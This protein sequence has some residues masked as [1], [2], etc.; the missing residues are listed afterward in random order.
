MNRFLP[1]PLLS[2]VLAIMWPVLN[3]TWSLGHIALGVVLA[4][5]IPWFTHGLQ[6]ELPT[7]RKPVLALRLFGVVLMDIVLS[8]ID[9]ARL[10]AK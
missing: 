8:N 1:S 7:L 3:Q 4:I 10:I 5:V 2:V 6:D 9:V